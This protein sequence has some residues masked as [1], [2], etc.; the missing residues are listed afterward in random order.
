MKTNLVKKKWSMWG[1]I[2]CPAIVLFV[3]AYTYRRLFFGFFEQD[4][5]SSFAAGIIFFNLSFTDQLK[6]LFAVS[7]VLTHF[8]PVINSFVLIMQKIFGPNYLVFAS[9]VYFLHLA[10]S[11]L[12]YILLKRVS[13]S[14]LFASGTALLFGVHA[15]SSQAVLWIAGALGFQTALFFY[16]LSVQFYLFYL[17]KK[18]KRNLF[19]SVFL[20]LCSILST[21]ATLVL[22]VVYPIL[23]LAMRK[24]K[25]SHFRMKDFKH[26]V[27]F[28]ALIA[29]LFITKYVLLLVN[30][31]KHAKGFVF[32]TLSTHPEMVF[33]KIFLYP[34]QA[35]SQVFDYGGWVFRMSHAVLESIYPQL[36][37]LPVS[38]QLQGSLVPDVLYLLLTTVLLILFVTSAFF[39]FRS[40]EK[41]FG[42]L[43]LLGLALFFISILPYVPLPRA[44]GF[45]ENRYYYVPNLF[46]SIVLSAVI[47]FWTKKIFSRSVSAASIAFVIVISV[48][49]LIN[50][51]YIR[52]YYLVKEGY[53]YERKSLLNQLSAIMPSLTG[54]ENVFFFTGKGSDF[55]IPDLKVPFQSG[56][57]NILMVLYY[58]NRSLRP[59]IL[60]DGYLYSHDSQGYRRLGEY[61][62][63]YFYNEADLEKAVLRNEFSPD[64]V[65]A[66]FWDRETM[67]LTEISDAVKKR[68]DSKIKDEK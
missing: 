36:A 56:L 9:Y 6:N 31:H 28:P 16:L 46:A 39:A 33:I 68:L 40:K 4:E 11:I 49:T 23:Y 35:L 3:V 19:L 60:D 20:F 14:V 5:W 41:K 7:H 12:V 53:A 55:L 21:E 43:I 64:V 59:E 45:L 30:P 50:I 66:F 27:I 8:T 22:I 10:N 25:F 62:F 13:K 51:L 26:I 24:S 61:G 38:G 54:K 48:I 42:M 63:G 58:D 17:Q 1:G 15:V 52:N 65:H 18:S 2:F 29:T 57:G 32:G 34:L 44:I 67:V 47:F 37:S